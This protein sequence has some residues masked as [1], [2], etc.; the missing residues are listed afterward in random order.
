MTEQLLGTTIVF[1]LYVI[2][3]VV[4]VGASRLARRIYHRR[5]RRNPLTRNLLRPPGHSLNKQL[6]D[7]WSDMMAVL[8]ASGAVP[9]MLWG[10]YQT[11]SK[12]TFVK[13]V[14]PLFG[15]GAL[16]VAA[17]RIFRNVGRARRVRLGWEAET[18]AGQELSLLMHDRFSVF[19]DIP[20]DGEFNIDHVVVGNQGVYCVETKGRAK[21]VHADG[22]GHKVRYDGKQLMFPGWTETKPLEQARNNAEWLRKWLS[23]AVGTAVDVRPVLVL[24]GWYIE[25]ASPSGVAVMNGVNC[26]N[27]FIK[28]TGA[29]LSDQLVKQIV[30]QL[31][32]RCRDVEPTTHKPLKD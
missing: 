22:E 7:I 18:A 15:I 13:V 1:A 6:D 3:I 17:H 29:P 24:P 12:S 31:D 30:H 25:R 26:R 27:F 28:G 2:P 9:L 16:A 23:S 8:A 19:H 32:A 14:V 11:S 4:L 20:G 5:D 10:L 21:P